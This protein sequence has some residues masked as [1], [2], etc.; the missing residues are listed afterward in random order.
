MAHLI[1][2]MWSIEIAHIMRKDYGSQDCLHNSLL[3]MQLS[4]LSMRAT[5]DQI[6]CPLSN[7]S[8][9]RMLAREKE[10]EEWDANDKIIYYMQE[11]IIFNAADKSSIMALF[12]S[13]LISCQTI[14]YKNNIFIWA[15]M[16]VK[17]IKLNPKKNIL[18]KPRLIQRRSLL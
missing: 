3:K 6:D 12:I 5:L 16:N 17:L 9:M 10:R 11:T 4:Y 13:T 1:R 2:P 18:K 14:I 15:I 8:S 7:G